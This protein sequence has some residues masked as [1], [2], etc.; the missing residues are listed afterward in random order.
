MVESNGSGPLSGI[1]VVEFAQVIAGPLA[2]TLLADLGADVVHIEPPGTGDSARHMGPAKDGTKLWWKV[3]GR[4][5]RSAT[6]DLRAEGADAVV[7]RLI[8]WA[9][10]VIV[11][12][13]DKTVRRFSLDWESVSRVNPSAILLQISGFGANT[14]K[15]DEPGFGKMAE[16][17]SGLVHLTG[18]EDGPPV[19]TGFSH[20]DATSGLMGAFAVCAALTRRERDV[21][22]KGEWIDLALSETLYRLVE[23]QVILHDQLG[24]VPQRS[25]NSLA[26]APG[27]VINTYLSADEQWITVTSATLRSVLNIVRLLGLNED[28][29]QTFEAQTARKDELDRRLAKWIAENSS[30]TVLAALD[31]AEVVASKIFDIADIFADETYAERENI[32]S[33]DDKD[34]G[35]IRMQAVI[36]H[37]RVNPGKVWRPGPELGADNELIYRDW[38]GLTADQYSQL[39]KSGVTS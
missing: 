35:P 21:E 5:K 3:L 34:L 6:L 17:R 2:G 32:V 39:R 28:E 7:R 15:R 18:F 38:L 9:D 11:T 23:W 27:A 20:G 14:T 30:D 4:N 16:A 25:G 22:R 36:P 24:I 19:H 37:L 12:F 13:R 10:V 26:V 8:E 31:E 33:V 1:K 29:F